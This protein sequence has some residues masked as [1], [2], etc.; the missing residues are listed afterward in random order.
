MF[1]ISDLFEQKPTIHCSLFTLHLYYDPRHK[2]LNL[3][4]VSYNC[5]VQSA[6]LDGHLI[7][8]RN[9]VLDLGTEVHSFVT[10]L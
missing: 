4:K 8:N 10:R 3:K 1:V 2:N 5:F 6:D 9:L 7:G